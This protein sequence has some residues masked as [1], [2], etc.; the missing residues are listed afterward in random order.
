MFVTQVKRFADGIVV[1]SP[2]VSSPIFLPI[3]VKEIAYGTCTYI[4]MYYNVK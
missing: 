4:Y 2:V 1:S 3:K